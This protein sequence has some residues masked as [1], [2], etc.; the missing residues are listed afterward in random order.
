MNDERRRYF[1]IDE[2]LRVSYRL[3][4]EAEAAAFSEQASKDHGGINYAANFD[5]RIQTLLDA[6]RIQAPLAAELIDLVNKKL[7]FVIQQMDIDAGLMQRVAY[8]LK[9][10]NVSACG[11]AFPCD[12]SLPVGRHIQLDL[13]LS[14]GELHIVALAEVVACSPAEEAESAYFVRVNFANISDNDQ[15]LLIQHI[16]K[17]QSNQLKRQ[18]L[19]S[20]QALDKE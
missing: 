19:E 7:N 15:E 4:G 11:M 9:Q 16:V 1:R 5:N 10:V 8:T 6:C 14:P 3:L 12:E 13:L 2:N 20:E 18:R 17:G